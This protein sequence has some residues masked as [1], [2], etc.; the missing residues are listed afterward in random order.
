MS[1]PSAIDALGP[2]LGTDHPTRLYQPLDDRIVDLAHR[3]GG[4]AV[5]E[6]GKTVRTSAGDGR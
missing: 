5:P 4:T 6:S 1:Q 2:L 3:W